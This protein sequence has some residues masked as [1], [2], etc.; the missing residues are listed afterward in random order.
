MNL[1][2]LNPKLLNFE[3]FVILTLFRVNLKFSNLK[4]FQK[5][6]ITDQCL[7]SGLSNELQ[8]SL[9]IVALVIVDS[10]IIVDKTA[11]TEFLLSNFSRY[12]GFSKIS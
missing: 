3:I 5:F 9:V 10:L 11:M 1:P 6:D 4:F 7:P 8:C 2:S 12:S